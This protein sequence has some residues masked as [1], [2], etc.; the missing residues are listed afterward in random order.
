MV[1][2]E[3]DAPAL[4]VEERSDEE[5]TDEAGQAESANKN[6]QFRPGVQCLPKSPRHTGVSD[7]S[8]LP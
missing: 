7:P 1:R 4:E 2:M 6:G 3:A 5:P 8:L